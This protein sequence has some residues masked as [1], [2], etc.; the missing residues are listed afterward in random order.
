[1]TDWKKI[2]NNADIDELL[3]EYAGFHDSC[4]ISV[5]QCTGVSVDE[6]HRMHFDGDSYIRL[7]FQS[8]AVSKTLELYFS[9]IIKYCLCDRGPI[10]GC[11]IGVRTGLYPPNKDLPLIVWTEADNTDH[12]LSENKV[13]FVISQELKWR[14]L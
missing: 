5:D 7:I 11:N 8:Q 6:R 2:G 1:M 9:G 13:N 12:V 4:I 14:L 10:F 3:N